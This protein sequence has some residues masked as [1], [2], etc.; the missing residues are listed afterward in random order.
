MGGQRWTIAMGVAAVT[1]AAVAN[2]H[3]QDVLHT[4]GQGAVPVFEGWD[5]QP[6]GSYDMIFGYLNR[7]TEE[8]LDVPI[9][10]DNSIEPGGPDQGQPAHFLSRRSKFVFRIHVPKDFGTKEL[11]WTLTSA[12][13]TEHA[14]ATLKRGYALSSAQMMLNWRAVGFQLAGDDVN[15]Q[16]PNIKLEGALQR[17]AKVGEPLTLKAVIT[18]D[19]RLKP[20]VGASSAPAQPA[21]GGRIEA[22]SSPPRYLRAGWLVYRGA[23]QVTFQPEQ[24]DPE[25]RQ[26][27][28]TAYPLPPPISSGDTVTAT[29]TFREPGTVVLR[30][31]AH[32]GGLSTTQD[33]TVAVTPR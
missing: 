7:N 29:A 23:Q 13:K 12:G 6:D 16:P 32:D 20:R 8:N 17:T 26:I 27:G 30:L 24:R 2:S 11:V 10:A 25:F 3:P 22:P 4:H 1:F 33:V 18:D 15:N 14:Y 31:M 19:G 28:N 9:G 5:Q 21:P